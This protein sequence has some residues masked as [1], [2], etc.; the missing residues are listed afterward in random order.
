MHFIIF[1]NYFFFFNERIR[2]THEKVV[3]I[4]YNDRDNDRNSVVIGNKWWKC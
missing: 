3:I 2:M 4:V 1:N